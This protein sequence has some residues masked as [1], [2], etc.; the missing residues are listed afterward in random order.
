MVR[1]A[2]AVPL[3]ANLPHAT[4]ELRYNLLCSIH[5]Y[6][7]AGAN[8]GDSRGRVPTPALSRF[9]TALEGGRAGTQVGGAAGAGAVALPAAVARRAVPA[10]GLAAALHAASVPRTG[11]VDKS[12]PSRGTMSC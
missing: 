12:T 6:L 11:T 2:T 4:G 5:G 10:S 7:L 3:A 1:S 8:S 9:V